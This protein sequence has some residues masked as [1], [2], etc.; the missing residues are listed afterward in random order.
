[1]PTKF[2]IEQVKNKFTENG[3][4]LLD[5]TY[6]NTS[7]KLN[8]T[9]S[10]GHANTIVFKCF[11]KGSGVKCKNCAFNVYTYD[12][13]VKCF[14]DKKCI[15]TMK[16]EEFDETYK[17]NSCKIK[18]NA[19]CGHENKVRFKN[20]T[21]LNQGICCPSCVNK[22]TGLILKQLRSDDKNGSLEQEYKCIIYVMEIIKNMFT[23]QKAFDGCKSDIIL[24]TKNCMEDKWLGIQVKT[25]NKKTARD[26]YYFRLNSSS[27]E[28]CLILCVCEEDKKMWLI[29][30]DVVNGMKTIGVAKK[31]KY[32]IYEVNIDNIQNKIENYYNSNKTTTFDILNTPTSD[33]QKQE[34]EFRKKRETKIDFIPFINHEIEGLVYDFM[35]N[36]KK[37]QEKVGTIIHKNK[38]SYMFILTKNIGRVNGKCT[39]GCYEKGDNDLYWLNCKNGLFYVIPEHALIQKGFLGSVKKLFVSPTNKNTDWC[40]KYLFDYEKI[41][42]ERL[43]AIVNASSYK[44]ALDSTHHR[45]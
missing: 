42:K 30:Y 35:I 29:P 2:T 26:Q 36:D 4:V 37:V 7:Q 1:M 11:L 40:N 20:F 33:T 23:A 8:Y 28:N 3:C 31:S 21:S 22:N 13:V 25:T 41:D 5:N 6:K 38:N 44:S 18:Y 10:C 12:D 15:V 34:Q 24:K 14:L 17:N 9:A 27:Y 39:H 45:N 19:S 16:K 43:L 32:N